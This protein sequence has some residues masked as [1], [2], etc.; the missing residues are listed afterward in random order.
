MVKEIKTGMVI[1]L[2]WQTPFRIAYLDGLYGG[3]QINLKIN[4][5][6]DDLFEM[7]CSMQSKLTEYELTPGDYIVRIF[8][9]GTSDK[10]KIEEQS[11]KVQIKEGMITVL[12]YALGSN[13]KSSLEF[14]KFKN[15]K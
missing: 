9:K 6:D 1:D 4:K 14:I 8:Y 3:G 12:K 11:M 2:G 13:Y 15:T 7:S 5:G 10:Y